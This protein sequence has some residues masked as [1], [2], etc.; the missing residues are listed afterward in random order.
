MS[1]KTTRISALMDELL[2]VS[3]E[4]L[5]DYEQ[6][7]I[8]EYLTKMRKMSPELLNLINQISTSCANQNAKTI[9]RESFVRPET[10]ELISKACLVSELNH[11]HFPGAPYVDAGISI[12]I[13]KVMEAPPVTTY[14][15]WIPCELELPK[16]KED[17]LEYPT[18]AV[19]LRNG[20]VTLACYYESTGEWGAGENFDKLCFPVAWTPLP[21]AYKIEDKG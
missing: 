5:T 9:K 4:G 18:V 10:G 20:D 16:S 13:G 19:T 12:A 15:N 1:D 11:S 21:K 14:P 17:D 6:G 7:L 3:S 8:K 2:K